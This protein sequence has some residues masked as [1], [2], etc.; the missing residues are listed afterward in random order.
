M[1]AAWGGRL[2]A[3]AWKY[4]KKKEEGSMYKPILVMTAWKYLKNMEEEVPEEYGGGTRNG[5]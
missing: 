1:T 5:E 4:L 2:A 3:T